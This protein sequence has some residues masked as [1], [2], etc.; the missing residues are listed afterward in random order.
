MNRFSLPENMKDNDKS[1]FKTALFFIS[2][3][4]I[5]D[6]KVIKYMWVND[7]YCTPSLHHKNKE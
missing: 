1:R 4:I 3:I 5:K 6:F 2:V 7:R